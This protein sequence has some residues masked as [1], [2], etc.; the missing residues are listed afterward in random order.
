M[1]MPTLISAGHELSND[2][3]MSRAA[4]RHRS[5]ALRAIARDPLAELRSGNLRSGARGVEIASPFLTIAHSAQDDPAVQRGVADA[6]GVLLRFCDQDLHSELRPAEPM[7]RVIFDLLEQLR[8]QALA[9]DLPGVRHNLEVAAQA[10]CQNARANGVAESGVGVLV[11]TLWHM[12][13]ARLRL[14]M[15]S[16]EVD[17]IIETPRARLGRLLGHGLKRLPEVMGDQAAYAQAATEIGRLLMEMAED[18]GLAGQAAE[19]ARYRMLVPPQWFDDETAGKGDARPGIVVSTEATEPLE[20]LGGY[21]AYTTDFD[22]ELTGAGLYSAEVRRGL[23]NKLDEHVRAQAVSA[24]RIAERLRRLFGTPSADD[25]Q[26]GVEDGLIDGR[27]L[28]QLVV[29]STAE[30]FRRQL[31]VVRS[32]TA[33]AI[34]MDNSGSMRAQRF[35]VLATLADTLSRALDLAG[36]TN[37]VLGFTTSTWSG[38]QSRALWKLDGEPESP[39]RV[40][41]IAHI[42]YK[43]GDTPYRRA[44]HSL[45]SM[46]LPRHF[47]ESVDGEAVAW[48]HHR[49]MSRPESRKVLLVISD[50]APGESATVKLNG[51]AFLGEHL[52]RVVDHIERRSPVEIGALTIDNDVSSIFRRSLPLDLDAAVTVGTYGVFEALFS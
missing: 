26:F 16:E 51:P 29:G 34:V 10:W 24:G 35:E 9:P 45:A 38:G 50:G 4:E 43:D 30:V 19:E 23:R 5:A 41:D 33:V 46:L 27:R 22:V 18:S 31:P 2:E 21:S 3:R 40:A 32:N 49:L 13:R 15:T 37:E 48:A 36:V 11:Y 28:S 25:W 1:P 7:Q 47:A 39:G 52:G 44:R 12:A 6:L 8:C 42:V 20:R 14:G 17:T